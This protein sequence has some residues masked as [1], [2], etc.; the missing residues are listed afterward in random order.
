MVGEEVQLGD[1]EGRGV[2]A[3][4]TGDLL[5]GGVGAAV[6]GPGRAPGTFEQALGGVVQCAAPPGGTAAPWGC[7]EGGGQ[8][9]IPVCTPWCEPLMRWPGGVCN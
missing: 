3:C 9:G 2:V 5:G 1:G 4:G 7:G 8:A 6:S